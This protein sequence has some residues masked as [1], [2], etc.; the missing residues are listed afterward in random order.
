MYF[1]FFILNTYLFSSKKFKYINLRTLI[2]KYVYWCK[3]K[4]Y[5]YICNKTMKMIHVYI[6]F[7][8][9]KANLFAKVAKK[10]IADYC[11]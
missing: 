3:G 7:N 11:M 6:V 5:K 9:Y 1:I 2:C 8:K 10:K 4:S